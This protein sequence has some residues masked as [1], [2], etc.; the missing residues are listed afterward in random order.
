[1]DVTIG[2][3][4]NSLST[5]HLFMREILDKWDEGKGQATDDCDHCPNLMTCHYRIQYSALQ[6]IAHTK[7]AIEEYQIHIL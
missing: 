3:Q 7:V 2:S 1:M 4:S 6:Y 5:V